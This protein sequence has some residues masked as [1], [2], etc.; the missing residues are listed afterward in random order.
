[1]LSRIYTNKEAVA[2]ANLMFGGASSE[3]LIGDRLC[4]EVQPPNNRLLLVVTLLNY[5][6]WDFELRRWNLRITREFIKNLDKSSCSLWG[7]V[8]DEIYLHKGIKSPKVK[9]E[10]RLTEEISPGIVI[11]VSDENASL[12]WD[13][14]NGIT[15]SRWKLIQSNYDIKSQCQE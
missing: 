14:Q 11:A 5:E 3:E 10:F 4:S 2:V 7:I 9:V 13:F 8:E 12:A 1:M 6:V 15:N